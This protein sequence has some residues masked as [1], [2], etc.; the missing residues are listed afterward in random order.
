MKKVTEVVSEPQLVQRWAISQ[1]AVGFAF[2]IGFKPQVEAP[3]SFVGTPRCGSVE[4][5]S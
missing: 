5:V 2:A 3:I 1:S 4:D